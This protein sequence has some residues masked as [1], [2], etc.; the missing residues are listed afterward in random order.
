MGKKWYAKHPWLYAIIAGAVGTAAVEIVLRCWRHTSLISVART[1]V[2]ALLYLVPVPLIVLILL[3]LL[4]VLF[5]V[6]ILRNFRASDVQYSVTRK[7]I[8]GLLWEFDAGETTSGYQVEVIRAICPK[9]RNELE[10]HMNEMRDR[11]TYC[12]IDC[13]KCHFKTELQGLGLTPAL[14]RARKEIERRI[15][16]NEQV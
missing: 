11:T 12:K 13:S 6:G 10:S 7:A 16:A 15:R 5:L 2:T 9:C 14:G 4:S 3:T 8:E 1:F